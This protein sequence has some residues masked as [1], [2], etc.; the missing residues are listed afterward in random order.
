LLRIAHCNAPGSTSLRQAA[1][2]RWVKEKLDHGKFLAWIKA[3]FDMAERSARRFMNVYQ[4][5]GSK[6]PLW[7]I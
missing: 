2:W 3:E 6:S 4:R 7:P 1:I 5:F